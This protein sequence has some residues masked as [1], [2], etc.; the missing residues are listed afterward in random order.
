MAKVEKRA[1]N[2]VLGFIFPAFS[3]TCLALSLKVEKIRGF[4]E[5]CLFIRDANQH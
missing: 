2:C 5:G 1:E 3:E 4:Y